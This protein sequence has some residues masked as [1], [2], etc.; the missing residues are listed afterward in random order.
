MLDT[1]IIGG[2]VCGLALARSLAK[3][4]RSFALYEARQRLG[5]RVLTVACAKTGLRVD[6]GPTWFWPETQPVITQLIGELGLVDFPQYDEGAVLVLRDPNKKPETSAAEGIHSGARRLDN[7]M[8]GLVEA[9]A[10]DVP[11]ASIHLDHVLVCVEDR[12]D[13][14]VLNLNCGQST[15]FVRAKRAVLAVPPR[16]L[17]EQIRFTPALD[18]VLVDA[19]RETPTWMAAQAK[20]VI[21]YERASW[22][23]NGYSGGAFVTHEQAVLGEIFDACDAAGVKPALGGFLSLSPELRESFATGLPLLMGNQMG[24]LFGHALEGCEQHYKDW[25]TEIFTCASLDREPPDRHPEFC[26]P[27]L[28]QPLWSGRLLL[29]TAETASYAGGYLEGALDAARRIKRD[30]DYA[31]AL[32]TNAGRSNRATGAVSDTNAASLAQFGDWVA[33]QAKPA[34][35]SYRHRLNHALAQQQ[36]EQL[37]QRAM[38]GAAEEV[39]SSALAKLEALPFDTTGVAIERGRSALTPEIQAPF[40]GFLPALLEDVTSYNRSSCALSNFPDEHHLPADYVQVILRD[41]AAAWREFSLSA[42][43]MLVAKADPSAP[44]GRAT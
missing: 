37:T 43:A 6:L 2:G 13:H 26:N 23:D 9:L 19:M 4:G 34:F 7:G 33:L 32:E 29:G 22:R 25:A 39:Y 11:E 3:D 5:G 15:V 18:S 17:A 27:M 44:R 1:A 31:L 20:A 14:V 16:L 41:I 35:E 8:A 42:N 10:K 40:H 36:K 24:Q 12:G 21:T 30:L 28:R 38:L